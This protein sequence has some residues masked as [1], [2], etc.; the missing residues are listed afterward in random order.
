MLI[1]S[2]GLVHF[3]DLCHSHWIYYYQYLSDLFI[4]HQTLRNLASDESTGDDTDGNVDDLQPREWVRIS[5]LENHD[6]TKPVKQFPATSLAIII[7]IPKVR[8]PAKP[9]CH[10]WR[11]EL[12]PPQ[13]AT[14][15]LQNSNLQPLAQH[16]V[17]AQRTVVL[18]ENAKMAPTLSFK[19]G[20][21]E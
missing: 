21:L 5:E 20:P 6:N 11:I 1:D 8:N 17:V 4:Y 13:F 3:C 16:G 14:F 12:L 7:A 18:F 10:S 2:I 15:S 9:K 19:L